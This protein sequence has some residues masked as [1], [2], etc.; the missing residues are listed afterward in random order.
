MQSAVLRPGVNTEKTLSANEAGVSQSQLIRYKD[1]M[2]QSYGGWQQYVPFTIGST[3]R[4][5]HAWQDA[6]AVDHLGVGATASLNAI[7][8]GSN[9]VITPQTLTINSNSTG[10]TL[11][12][13]I[14]SR[15]VTMV[16]PNSSNAASIYNTVFFNTQISHVGQIISGAYP[17]VSILSTDSFTFLL[18]YD[19]TASSS[20]SAVLPV[21]NSTANSAIITVDFPHN[22]YQQVTGLFYPF[23][24]P[25]TITSNLIIEGPYQISSIIDSTEFTINAAVQS[26]GS[27][28][29]VTMNSSVVQAVFYV[30]LGPAAAGTGFGAGGFGSGGFGGIASGGTAPTQGTPI[31]ATDWT[32]DNWGELLL[33][34][35]E[36]GA[37]YTWAPDSG[38]QNAQVIAQA[39]FF[40]GGM[41]V[42]MPQQI[43][44]CWRSCQPN[45]DNYGGWLSQNNLI[46]TWSD[47]EDFTNWVVSN[48]TAGGSFQIPTGSILMGGLQAASQGILWTDIDVWVMQYIGGDLTFGFNRVGSGCGLVG[49]HAAASLGGNVYWCGTLNFFVMDTNGVKPLNCSVWD[50]VFQNLNTTYQSKIVCA[51]NTA[52]NEVAWFFPSATSTGENDSYAKYN[53]LETEWDYGTLSRTAWIDVSV[54]GNPIG[55][56]PTSTIFQHETGTSLA[57]VASPSF[58]SGYWSLS[59]GNDLAFVDFV[60]PDFIWG[61]YSGAKDAELLVTFYTQD[62]PGGA[63]TTYG[64]FTITASTEYI[65]LRARGRL[66]AVMVQSNNSEFFR[67]GRVRFRWA[68]SGRR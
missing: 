18:P 33:A 27:V 41:F 24:A 25:T 6:A 31:S 65:P 48:A 44:V 64:P 17:I 38:F 10:V 59:D 2:I 26:T 5:M 40:N 21:F 53:V 39:P 3:I 9:T 20:E 62:Y 61:T 45:P 54:L 37:V 66:M 58:K 14:A 43:L 60:I 68:T 4:A 8:A 12:T 47:A 32:M 63:T 35:P 56:D 28:A 42:S 13:T 1:G 7:T 29:N 16:L 22:N 34:C 50:S 55:A 52:F 36:G 57:G 49:K 51:T 23:Y 15:T 30:T 46:V 67:L 11:S 19:S